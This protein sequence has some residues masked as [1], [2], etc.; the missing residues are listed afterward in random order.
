VRLFFA[1]WP[2]RETAEAL[3]AWAGEVSASSGGR[4]TATENIHLTLAFLGESDPAKAAQAA[5]RV[6]GRR[7]ELPIESAKYVKRNDM[8]WVGPPATPAPLAEL[9]AQLHASLKAESFV[10]EDRPFAAHVTLVRKAR[11]PTSLPP[12]PRVG[13][14]VNE[15]VLIRSHTSSRGSTYEPLELIALR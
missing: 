2:P 4:V 13:W 3:A 6:K 9:V 8:V 7:H 1:L 10:L 5:R 15:F 11:R 14:P 12:L